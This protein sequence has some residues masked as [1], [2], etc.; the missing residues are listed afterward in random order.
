MRPG[1]NKRIALVAGIALAMISLALRG[2]TFSQEAPT[3]V[4]SSEPDYGQQWSMMISI[5]QNTLVPLQEQ[6]VAQADQFE[7]AV[8]TFRDN[9]SLDSLTA[10]QE[11]WRQAASAW[12]SADQI[13]LERSAPLRNQINKPPANTEF[14][15][16]F[17][18]DY[19]AIDA[20]FIA[21]VGSTAKGLSA[22]EYLIF[23]SAGDNNAVLQTF[24]DAPRAA[25]RV[26]YLVSAVEA[27]RLVGT[28]YLQEWY[29]Q[30]QH[31]T[32]ADAEF[33]DAEIKYNAIMDLRM[34]TN[35]WIASLESVLTTDLADPMGLTSGG[36]S[37]PELVE[38]PRAHYSAELIL[39]YLRGFKM[40]FHGL[41]L[42]GND[43]EGYDDGLDAMDAQFEGQAL[44][45]VIGDQID[46]VIHS[47]EKL[48]IPLDDAL[49]AEPDEVSAVHDEMRTL[50]RLV[51]ADMTSWLSISLIYSDNDGD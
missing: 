16:G 41:S 29:D 36:D 20:N 40:V 5:I 49:S 35:K 18:N 42:D 50:A 46:T 8:H 38:A 10:L 34:M 12:A 39:A 17:L 31:Y 7:G 21:G 4:V 25:Q 9:P 26:Q 30:A 45:K 11:S 15:E 32:D 3:P 22:V 2:I 1:V 51:H 44:S 19:D 43:H 14:I 24:T 28:Q 37:R 27:I 48:D 13:G 6:F 33:D 47:L 23:D